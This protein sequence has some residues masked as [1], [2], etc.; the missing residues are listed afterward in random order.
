MHFIQGVYFS[1]GGKDTMEQVRVADVPREQFCSIIVRYNSSQPA[2][3]FNQTSYDP[4]AMVRHMFFLQLSEYKQCK[5]ILDCPGG[6]NT[7]YKCMEGYKFHITM[8][9]N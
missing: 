5:R 6:P 4:D 3:M 8:V 7:A 9:S 2:Q 1:L